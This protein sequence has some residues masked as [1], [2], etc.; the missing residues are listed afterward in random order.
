MGNTLLFIGHT[1]HKKT[2]SSE[3]LLDILRKEYD[4][5]EVYINPEYA[6]EYVEFEKYQGQTFDALVI[7]QVMPQIQ[8]LSNYISWLHAVY[9]PMYDHYYSMGR[10]FD[11]DWRYYVKMLIICFSK[12]MQQE[13]DDNGFDTR[14]IQYFPE[15]KPVTNWGAEDSV[16]FWQRVSFLNLH[17][18]AD[19]MRDISIR[20][21]HHHQAIDPC[22]T[23]VPLS[24]YDSSVQSF[25]QNK[26]LT[27]SEW[28]E[29]KAQLQETISR[30][31]LYM[32]PRHLEGI[33]MSFLEAMAQGRCVIA[34][35]HST[36]NEYITDGVNGLLYPWNE[37]IES[38]CGAKA[39]NPTLSI[40]EIQQNSYQSIVDGYARWNQEKHNI[41]LWLRETSHPDTNKLRQCAA[42][43]GW[44]NGTYKESKLLAL[45]HWPEFCYMLKSLTH[46]R[47]LDF[48]H[49]LLIHF[50]SRFCRWWYLAKY[51]DIKRAGVS[52]AA[53]YL[54]FGWR[55]GRDP[56]SCFSSRR[57]LELNPD[58]A[59]LNMCPLLH[60][61]LKGKKEKRMV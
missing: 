20:A 36:M 13:L 22:H 15:P 34:P 29:D 10:L 56:S 50:N 59:Q 33:G 58:V 3:F 37:R 39:N 2:K 35:D 48:Y 41:L 16:F 5:V 49:F 21:V 44:E 30:H 25:Y 45:C 1:Y 28:F 26:T 40:R 52:P 38:R 61:K 43:H 60:W 18:L 17:T 12:A 23:I 9:F 32:A 53:H 7:W 55:E 27:V 42:L 31:A 6:Y 11:S 46:G 4:V 8:E 51:E 24:A 19:A 57:Y 54:E 47:F 14:Y